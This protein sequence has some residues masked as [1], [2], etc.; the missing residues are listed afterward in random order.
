[1]FN[2]V[3]VYGHQVDFDEVTKGFCGVLF[4]TYVGMEKK[5]VNRGDHIWHVGR[6]SQGYDVLYR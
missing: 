1:M 3:S 6:G 4:P 5:L 2:L